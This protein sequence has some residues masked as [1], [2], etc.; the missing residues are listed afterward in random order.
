MLKNLTEYFEKDAKL[1]FSPAGE[2]QPIS[3][4]VASCVVLI[5]AAFSDLWYR[6]SEREVIL[7]VLA[8]M[9]DEE[10]G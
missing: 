1:K 5:E 4:Q 10:E 3:V 6:S 2:V 9:L 7:E 8:Q